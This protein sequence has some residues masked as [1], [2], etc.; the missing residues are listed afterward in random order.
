M[1]VPATA[2]PLASGEQNQDA[3]RVGKSAQRK[4]HDIRRRQ[5]LKHRR[6]IR[7]VKC[8][9]T[10]PQCKR[11]AQSGRICDGYVPPSAEGL[12]RRALTAAVR[13]LAAPGPACR[14]LAGPQA[15]DDVACFDFFRLRTAP[16]AGA[17]FPTDFWSRRVLQAAHGE[18]AIWSATVALGALHRRWETTAVAAAGRGSPDGE[19]LEARFAAQATLCYG[20]ALRL[21]RSIHQP[22]ALLMLSLALAAVANLAGQWADARVHITSGQKLL[23][24]MRA[25]APPGADLGVDSAAESLARMEMQGI[26]FSEATAPYPYDESDLPERGTRWAPMEINNLSQA[27]TRLFDMFSRIMVLHGREPSPADEVAVYDGLALEMLIRDELVDWE[28][29]VRMYLEAMGEAQREKHEVG[30][31]S[32]KLY[33]AM[34]R[35]ALKPST[36]GPQ[37]R[38]DVCLAHF[39]RVVSLSAAL[40]RVTQPLAS[41]VVSVDMGL[42]MPLYVTATRCR[43]PALRRSAITLLRDSNRHEGMWQSVG[44]TVVAAKIATLEEEGLGIEAP[45]LMHLPAGE[46]R[47]WTD[48]FRREEPRHWLGGDETW[49][50]RSSWIDVPIVPE[51]QRFIDVY[52][53]ADVDGKTARLRMIYSGADE[54]NQPRIRQ[55]V[56][57]VGRGGRP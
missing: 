24:Q 51:S 23:A 28:T 48:A 33:H 15:T 37:T 41:S 12:S 20:Q 36:S 25:R 13:A 9:E 21:A 16:T 19:T 22:A 39:E 32:L 27:A 38:W 5:T 30:L 34:V 8:D 46:M 26:L 49:S 4:G 6:R 31:L 35:L 14:I 7:R 42:V 55:E 11:C 10:K 45:M 40:L 17:F 29:S 53:T 43:H 3:S 1:T 54:N 47:E 52:L 57:F 44:A 2:A 50:A 56:V 18:P